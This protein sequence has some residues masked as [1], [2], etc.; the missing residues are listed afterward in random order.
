MDT[1]SWLVDSEK[2]EPPKPTIV[3]KP[4]IVSK[5]SIISKPTIIFNFNTG[6]EGNKYIKDGDL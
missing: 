6:C 4:S 3:P 1:G 2:I 5:P